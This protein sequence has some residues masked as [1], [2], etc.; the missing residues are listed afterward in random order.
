MPDGVLVEVDVPFEKLSVGDVFVIVLPKGKDYS[1]FGPSNTYTKIEPIFGDEV[2]GTTIG[3]ANC[4]YIRR[5]GVATEKRYSW[6]LP[7]MRCRKVAQPLP[8][9]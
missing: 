4:T 8:S 6:F 7:S 5:T 2:D 9:K 3:K 1:D